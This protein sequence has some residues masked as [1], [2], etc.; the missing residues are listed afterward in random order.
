MT[1]IGGS[2]SG[3]CVDWLRLN[4]ER[5][6][7]KSHNLPAPAVGLL[8]LP[9]LPSSHKHSKSPTTDIAA[10]ASSSPSRPHLGGRPDSATRI[11]RRRRIQQCVVLALVLTRSKLG[12]HVQVRERDLAYE[13]LIWADEVAALG[14]FFYR[15]YRTSYPVFRK[16][17][18]VRL[19]SL[20]RNEIQARRRHGR[21]SGAAGATGAKTQVAV[22]LRFFAGGSYLDITASH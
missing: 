12:L 4:L 14:A 21:G 16:L 15:K 6:F 18:S 9:P 1:G 8:F 17:L 2:W 7:N 22:A 10:M 3:S 19:R 20:E 13:R 5:L 11:E